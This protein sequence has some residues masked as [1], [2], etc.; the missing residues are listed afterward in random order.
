M[1]IIE[2]LRSPPAT[3]SE[4]VSTSSWLMRSRRRRSVVSD[5]EWMS[6]QL[7]WN[8]DWT[9]NTEPCNAAGIHFYMP[10][11]V[12]RKRD[13]EMNCREWDEWLAAALN[14]GQQFGSY[15]SPLSV[16][17]TDKITG[18]IEA[19]TRSLQEESACLLTLVS[20]PVVLLGSQGAFRQPIHGDRGVDRGDRGAEWRNLFQVMDRILWFSGQVMNC[21]DWSKPHR[22]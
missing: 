2:Y 4:A 10:Y 18:D 14:C 3:A 1:I 19:A 13:S 15:L 22:N 9:L 17:K 12:D 6:V 20:W 21:V 5:S 8:G 16:C 11:F 7:L